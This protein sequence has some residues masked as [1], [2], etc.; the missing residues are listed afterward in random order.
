M[1]LHTKTHFRQ[2]QSQLMRNLQLEHL[3]RTVSADMEA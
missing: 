3:T 1:H 2:L